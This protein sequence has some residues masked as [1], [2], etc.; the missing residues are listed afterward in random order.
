MIEASDEEGIAEEKIEE[1][2]AAAIKIR[3]RP[4]LPSQKEVDEHFAR[5]HCPYRNWCGICV[6]GRAPNNHHTRK[7]KEEERRKE[8]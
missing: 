3:N 7:D 4:E 2:E 6:K 8:K 5:N 1:E